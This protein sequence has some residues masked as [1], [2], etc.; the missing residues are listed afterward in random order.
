[1]DTLSYVMVIADNESGSD[2]QGVT[3]QELAQ[4]MQELGCREAYNL[5]GGN[6]A[7]LMYNGNML[8]NKKGR[9][10]DVTDMIYF[11]TAVPPEEWEQ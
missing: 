4:F 11:A 1:L 9:E 2:E 5:D 10:R 7:V 8:N 3:H 6:S